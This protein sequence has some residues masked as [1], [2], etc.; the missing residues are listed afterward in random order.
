MWDKIKETFSIMTNVKVK[1]DRFDKYFSNDTGLPVWS[2]YVSKTQMPSYSEPT[3]T[4]TY[5]S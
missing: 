5:T 2:E 1:K 4:S 3:Y